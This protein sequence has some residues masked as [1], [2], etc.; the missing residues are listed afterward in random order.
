M[1]AEQVE[2]SR[3]FARTIAAIEPQW[4]EQVAGSLIRVSYADPH[5][6][7][8]A[9]RAVGY[10]R[11]SSMGWRSFRGDELP[12]PNSVRVRPARPARS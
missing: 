4:I 3:L 6:E 7:K 10:A 12:G 2:T 9:G 1:A 5:W 11:G 8:K